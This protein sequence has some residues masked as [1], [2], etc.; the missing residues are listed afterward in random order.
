MTL[1][2]VSRCS[3]CNSIAFPPQRNCQVCGQRDQSELVALPSEGTLYTFTVIHAA[4]PGVQTP[5]AIGYAD[6]SEECRLFGRIT[7]C[8]HLRVGLRVQ[9]ILRDGR[10]AFEPIRNNGAET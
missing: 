10:P 1:L 8:D 2:Q 3:C 4:P 7:E 6:F 9:L 5:Y